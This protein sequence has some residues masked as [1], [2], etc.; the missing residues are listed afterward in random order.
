MVVDMCRFDVPVFTTMVVNTVERLVA[1]GYSEYEARAYVALLG[2]NPATAYEVAKNSGIPSSKVYE[3]MSRLCDKEMATHVAVGERRRYVPVEPA[4][5]VRDLRE[6][7]RSAIEGLER[8]L[9][10]LKTDVGGSYVWN[11][12]DY[13]PLM[14]R[15]E[16][17]CDGAARTLLGSMWPQESRRLS[18]CLERA[19]L[20]GVRTAV[21]HFGPGAPAMTQVYQHPIQ[22]TIYAEKGGRGFVLVADSAE[23]LMGTI[24]DSGVQG[25]RSRNRGFVTLAEDYIKHDV[26]IMKIVRRFDALLTTTFGPGYARLRDIY[27]DEEEST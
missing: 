2:A 26:Y 22:D 25:A 1:L 27:T 21:V 19:T 5:L 13:D 20:R 16:R 12:V 17:L 10:S 9:A 7:T 23:C 24:S 18:D 4:D 8:D 6:S 15:A 11:V 3:V 14:R